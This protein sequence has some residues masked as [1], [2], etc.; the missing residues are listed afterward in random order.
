MENKFYSEFDYQRLEGGSSSDYRTP[1]QKDRDR[2]IHSAAFRRLQSK[3]QVFLSGQ[4]DFYRTRLTHSMEVAQIGRSICQYLNQTSPHLSEDFRIDPDL[5]EAACLAHDLGHPPFGHAGEQTLNRL[6]RQ[7]SGFEGNAQTLRVITERF[8]WEGDSPK[9]MNPTRAFLDSILKYKAHFSL[10]K[11]PKRHFVYDNQRKYLQFAL[12]LEEF[13]DSHQSA[14]ELNGFRS[15]ECQIMD[16]ADDTAY[17][18]NDVVDGVNAGFFTIT[19]IERWAA[20]QD[21]RDSQQALLEWLLDA[22]KRGD[23]E[24]VLARKIGEFIQSVRLIPVENF[25]S[26]KTNRY[27]YRLEI[28]PEVIEQAQLL[29][30]LSL[31]NVFRSP[32]LHQLE[33]KGNYMLGK[34]FRSLWDNY[35]AENG[36]QYH[37][38]PGRLEAEIERV[39]LTGKPRL[40]CDYLAE[41]TDLSAM[42]IYKRLFDPD[43]GSIVDLL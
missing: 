39:G 35:I 13:P 2:I 38:L 10:Y 33:Y 11:N 27:A 21:L 36:G 6:M 42:Q 40:L 24:H 4:Y 31:E 22:L 16:W 28:L 29:K 9:G 32:E 12:D 1:F 7:H 20:S 26:D 15:I 25:M 14:E 19:R 3:T 37:L 17:S 30:K 41:Q 23:L 8:Y 43:F 18:I 34:I 5:V